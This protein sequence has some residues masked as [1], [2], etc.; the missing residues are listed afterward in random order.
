MFYNLFDYTNVSKILSDYSI[1][2]YKEY[3]RALLFIRMFK[4]NL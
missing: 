3:Y 1:I 4:C 2:H